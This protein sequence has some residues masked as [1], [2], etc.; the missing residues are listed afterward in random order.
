MY[1]VCAILPLRVRQESEGK[2]GKAGRG[3]K[4]DKF[5]QNAGRK[6]KARKE[7]SVTLRWRLFRIRGK[8]VAVTNPQR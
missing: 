7:N 4:Y 5:K 6:K 1:K 2:R 8:S 3:D